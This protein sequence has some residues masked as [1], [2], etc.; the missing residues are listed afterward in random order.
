MHVYEIIWREYREDPWN[1]YDVTNDPNAIGTI[2]Y[3]CQVC[4]PMA[5][6]QVRVH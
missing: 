2:V 1:V 6:V 3:N 4:H 5:L